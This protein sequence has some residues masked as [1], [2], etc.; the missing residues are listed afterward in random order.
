MEYPIERCKNC[1]HCIKTNTPYLKHCPKRK[2][3][4][5]L[6][7]LFVCIKT[8]G[9]VD[10]NDTCKFFKQKALINFNAKK[11]NCCTLRNCSCAA[12]NNK[13]PLKNYNCF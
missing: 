5:S 10:C 8:M 3:Y 9:I 11:L 7:S 4:S 6:S 12:K 13:K 1:S 2:N